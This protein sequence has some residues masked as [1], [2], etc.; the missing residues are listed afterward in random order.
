MG[1]LLARARLAGPRE[2]LIV[3]AVQLSKK[4]CHKRARRL[5]KQA[6]FY[7]G[8]G[9]FQLQRQPIIATALVVYIPWQDKP[10]AIGRAGHFSDMIT[11][12][13]GLGKLRA[14]RSGASSLRACAFAKG[15]VLKIGLPLLRH[16][17]LHSKKPRAEKT[18]VA[19]HRRQSEQSTSY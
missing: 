6:P 19:G 3:G 17:F 5:F 14:T 10:K 9:A 1:G 7:T 13:F 8:G 18:N 16:V 15:V 2:A 4:G 12:A 11:A